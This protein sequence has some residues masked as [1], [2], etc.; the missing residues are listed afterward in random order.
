MVDD[1]PIF[2]ATSGDFTP[3]QTDPSLIPGH[4]LYCASSPSLH[5]LVAVTPDHR[6][7]HGLVLVRLVVIVHGHPLL[8]SP[9][10]RSDLTKCLNEY[11]HIKA[12]IAFLK[13][14][15]KSMRIFLRVPREQRSSKAETGTSVLLRWEWRHDRFCSEKRPVPVRRSEIEPIC[16]I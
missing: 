15:V 14:P 3:L 6:S 10:T 7:S 13:E 8:L 11:W 12:S 4:A 16:P 1:Q 2:P 5:R 9:C